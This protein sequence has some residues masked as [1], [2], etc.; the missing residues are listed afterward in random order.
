[1]EIIIVV[2]VLTFLFIGAFRD[3]P[4]IIENGYEDEI[5]YHKGKKK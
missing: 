3:K 5:G 1:M 2:L 4:R